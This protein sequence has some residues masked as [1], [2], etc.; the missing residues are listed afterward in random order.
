MYW[1]DLYAIKLNNR[2]TITKR[3]SNITRQIREN[4]YNNR[5]NQED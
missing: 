5:V 1:I 4:M 2:T 3:K